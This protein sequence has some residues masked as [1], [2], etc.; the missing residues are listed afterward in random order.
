MPLELLREISGEA[1]PFEVRDQVRI[2]KLRVLAAAQMVEVDLPQAGQLGLA[3]VRRITGYGRAALGNDPPRC[4]IPPA[5]S[6]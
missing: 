3:V 6:D 5:K 2:D 4:L 1:L